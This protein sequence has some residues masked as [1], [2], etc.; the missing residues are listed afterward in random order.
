MH[1][2]LVARRRVGA[3][4]EHHKRLGAVGR[5]APREWRRV[6]AAAR[7]LA[8]VAARNRLAVAQADAAQRKRLWAAA[9]ARR[10]AAVAL[11]RRHGRRVAGRLD[12]DHEHVEAEHVVREERAEQRKVL[13]KRR[14][15]RE[16]KLG[17]LAHAQLL[18]AFAQAVDQLVDAVTARDV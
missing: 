13:A 5:V 7:H 8:C 18:N 15:R 11:V 1:R 14:G 12:V 17:A 4:H 2:L 3:A 6:V 9:L 16:P 10:R